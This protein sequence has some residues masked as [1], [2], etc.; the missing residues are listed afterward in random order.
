[1]AR[2]DPLADIARDDAD[3]QEGLEPD[4][5]GGPSEWEWQAEMSNSA[6]LSGGRRSGNETVSRL[7]RRPGSPGSGV[8]IQ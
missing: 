1:M 8:A 5:R 3:L 4:A 6:G 2:F 7:V